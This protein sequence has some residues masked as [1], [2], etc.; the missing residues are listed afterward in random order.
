MLRSPVCPG[1]PSFV[2]QSTPYPM[3]GVDQMLAVKLK[4]LELGVKREERE[5]KAFD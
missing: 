3:V 4:E 2:P 5:T 1:E